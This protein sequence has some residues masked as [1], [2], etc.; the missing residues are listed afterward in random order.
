MSLDIIDAAP[1]I[2]ADF[3][4]AGANVQ[5]AVGTMCSVQRTKQGQGRPARNVCD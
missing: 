3:Y 2:P 5:K 4:I 1:G